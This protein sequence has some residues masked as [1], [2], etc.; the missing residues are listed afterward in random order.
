MNSQTSS[1]L[2]PF[3]LTTTII[4]GGNV[5]NG[6][7]APSN[8]MPRMAYTQ[9]FTASL[10]ISQAR[11]GVENE[12]ERQT[13]VAEI[14][15]KID[16]VL[17]DMEQNKLKGHF[18]P[19]VKLDILMATQKALAWAHNGDMAA[20]LKHPSLVQLKRLCGVADE[21]LET[22]FSE[23]SSKFLGKVAPLIGSHVITIA[24][25][26]AGVGAR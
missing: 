19:A 8:K 14:V 23:S 7:H 5:L 13:R 16:G 22:E 24:N 17:I 26:V 4:A 18:T 3:L 6:S 2:R 1:H 12:S 21:H 9:R 20:A 25:E 15:G 11:G 10:A